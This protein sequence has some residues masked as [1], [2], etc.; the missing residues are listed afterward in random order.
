MPKTNI[1]FLWILTC[2]WRSHLSD[3]KKEID[4]IFDVDDEQ[5]KALFNF[6]KKK[7]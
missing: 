6:Q 3:T 1:I 4:Y 5:L 7:H 2:D